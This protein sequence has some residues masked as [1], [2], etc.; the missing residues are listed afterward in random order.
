MYR[1]N[2]DQENGLDGVCPFLLAGGGREGRYSPGCG[3]RLLSMLLRWFAGGMLIHIR[4]QH[5][6]PDFGW[7]AVIVAG[8]RI[9]FRM[10]AQRIAI[11][12][13]LASGGG[14]FMPAAKRLPG[15]YW[16]LPQVTGARSLL[17]LLGVAVLRYSSVLPFST[18]GFVRR[19]GALVCGSQRF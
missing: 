15:K 2:S 3:G 6:L 13:F 10:R 19:V 5:G 4:P 17:L 8:D 16:L 1:P 7:Q 12:T 9:Y 14:A 11:R 18:A